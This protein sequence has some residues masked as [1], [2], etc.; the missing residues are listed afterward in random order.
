MNA[1]NEF[2]EIIQKAFLKEFQRQFEE[3]LNPKKEEKSLKDYSTLELFKELAT[4][5]GIHATDYQL[6]R[7]YIDEYP[8]VRRDLT[9]TYKY[10]CSTGEIIE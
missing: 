6:E 10:N 4:R 7:Q 1:S 2:K 8:I 3:A 5:N 9:L